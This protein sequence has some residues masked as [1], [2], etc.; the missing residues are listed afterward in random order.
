MKNKAL[1]LLVIFSLL[2]C[3]A[4]LFAKERHGAELVVHKLDRQ[5][6]EGELIAVRQN[7][8]LLLSSDGIDVSVDV[9]DINVIII[10]KKSK[11]G[12]GAIAGLLI[13]GAA[14]GYF[15]QRGKEGLEKVFTPFA[16]LVYGILGSIVGLCIG[17]TFGTDKAIKI[18][19]KSGTEIQE[20]LEKLRRQARITNI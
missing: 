9:K 3:S 19:G 15:F 11:A 5:R 6:I 1:A 2:T 10:E 8:L 20:I 14:G 18:E 16:I 17:A 13:G 12:T 7:S 4:N